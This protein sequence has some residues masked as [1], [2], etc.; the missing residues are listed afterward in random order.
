MAK[1]TNNTPI[2]VSAFAHQDATRKNI[3]TQ[4]M[5]PIMTDKAKQAVRVSYERRNPDLDPQLIWRGKYDGDEE[6]SVLA[7]PL[8]VQ[9]KVKPQV[10]IDDLRNQS[11]KNVAKKGKVGEAAHPA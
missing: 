8:F 4:E 7:P 1:K 2:E 5:Q 9:E 11:K 6:L 10:L 3:P